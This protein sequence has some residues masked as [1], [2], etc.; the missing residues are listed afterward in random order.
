MD[1][2]LP[3]VCLIFETPMFRFMKKIF[4]LVLFLITVFTATAQTATEAAEPLQ[5]KEMEWDFG[6]VPQG[7]PVYHSFEIKN[8]GT[9]PVTLNNVQ[10]SCG[11]TTPEWSKDAIAPGATAKIKVG[12]NAAAEGAFEKYISIVYNDLVQKQIKIKGNVWRAP[13][14]AAPANASVSFLKQQLQ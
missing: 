7:K 2:H 10:A 9:K 4:G 12:F 11:C 14:G 8:T 6:S 3:P 5:F 13:A 1:W